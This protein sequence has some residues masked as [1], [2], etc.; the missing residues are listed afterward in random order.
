M[1]INPLISVIVPVYKVEDYIRECIESICKQSY[2]NL[3]IILVDDGSPDN[4]GKICDKYARMN[5][6]IMVIHKNNEG[7]SAARKVGLLHASGKY[8]AFVDSDDYIEEDYFERLVKGIERYQS[9]IVCCNCVDEGSINQPNICISRESCID[10]LNDKMKCYF[11]GMRFAYVIWGKIFKREL[12][13][14]VEMPLMRYTEDTHIMLQSLQLSKKIVLLDYNGYHYRVQA[15]SAMAT[16]KKID[17]IRDTLITI[18]LVN[19]ICFGM[20][21]AYRKKSNEMMRKYLYIAVLENCKRDNKNS[22]LIDIKPYLLYL[23][24]DKEKSLKA[25]KEKCIILI[26]N[27]N[28]RVV[29]K[30]I[31]KLLK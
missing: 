8:V 21:E 28:D 26:Y 18:R 31:G 24:V 16:S 3:E 30:I 7:V 12:I 6:N 20:D 27:K 15:E 22:K 11:D 4:S 23:N 10:N 5:N 14:K 29:R 2:N 17:V 19:D 13:D 9:D 1:E 25:I